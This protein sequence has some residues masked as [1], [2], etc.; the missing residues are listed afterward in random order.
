MIAVKSY[1]IIKT[2]NDIILHDFWRYHFYI[3]ISSLTSALC[4]KVF[5]VVYFLP[6][7]ILITQWLIHLKRINFWR[8]FQAVS[9]HLLLSSRFSSITNVVRRSMRWS[10]LSHR[11]WFRF[12]ASRQI[13]DSGT[14]ACSEAISVHKFCTP[15]ICYRSHSKTSGLSRKYFT[16]V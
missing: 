11:S 13:R 15:V 10:A 1:F 12:T 5:W 3:S 14:V 4:S 2:N 16:F 6:S 8:I 9:S 7:C